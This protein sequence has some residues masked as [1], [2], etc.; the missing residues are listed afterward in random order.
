MTEPRMGLRVKV[1]A[2]LVLAMFATLTTRLWFLQVLAAEQYKAEAKDNAVRLIEVPAPRGVIKDV[3]GTLLVQNRGSVVITINR[4]ALGDQTERVLFDLSELLDIPADELGARL[5]DPRYYVFSPIP[6]A[7]DVPKRVAYYI[8]EHQEQ[9]PGVDV[10]FEP[11][12]KYPL[13]SAGAH[14][15]GYLG[16]ISEDKL[17]DPGFADY[18]P[19][20]VIG[21]SGI[22]GI[23][24]RYLGG[25]RGLVKYRV[26]ST[27]K[28]LGL[29]GRQRPVAGDDVWLTLDAGTQE[30]AEQSLKAGIEHARTIAESDS[31]YLRANGGAAI[32]LDPQTG[33]I[34]AMASYPTFDPSL[35]TR[36]FS[37]KE[38]DRRFG[39]GHSFPLLNRAI[40]GQYPPGSTYKPFVA[41]SALQR[42]IVTTGGSYG[43][44][45]YWT[46]PYEESDPDAVQYVFNNWTTANLGYMNLATALAKSCDTVFYPMGYRYWD[47]FYVNDDEQSH[48]VV[49]HEP[50]QRDLA[51]FGFGAQT[52]VDLPYEQ[53]GRVPDAGWKQTI[54][55]QYP[56]SFPEGQW[57]PGDFILMTIGQGDTLVTPLQLAVAYG[58]L[59]NN[60]KQCV[61][62]VLDRVVAPDDT[63]VREYQEN[64]RKRVRVDERY[65]RYVRDAL[66]GTMTGGGTA[67][68]AFAGFPFG[69]VWVA[70]KTG[71]AEV[72]PKQDYSWFAAMTASGGQE[73]VVVVLVEQG[74]HGA[75]TA[76]P[77]ARHIIE[78]LYGLDFSAFTDVE[79]TD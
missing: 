79:G 51:S 24:E 16:Q 37:Q 72:P 49:S 25:T 68:A 78:G 18:S 2:A 27:G 57:F 17:K 64:C 63:V 40:Q 53:D 70:G 75:T 21:V 1:L 65:V 32:V 28:N 7:T 14:V 19:G 60:G 23:Y 59:E 20:D 41:S 61:P 33:A 54:H 73:H 45:P 8:E 5:D 66:T 35:F 11:V 10:L 34:E 9:F 30:L 44:P 76:A 36:G 13:G 6:V 3:N 77:I 38:F 56:E 47:M 62:H 55:E 22:E 58:A 71:T 31:G 50:L 15:L 4:Q 74:G 29:I 43:C 67:A 46:A 48:G 26:N 52:R 39:A 42:N 69:D 12:R